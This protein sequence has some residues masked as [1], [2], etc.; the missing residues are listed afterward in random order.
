PLII[1]GAAGVT[2]QLIITRQPLRVTATQHRLERVHIVLAPGGAPA[3]ALL[4]VQCQQVIV[5][6]CRFHADDSKSSDHSISTSQQLTSTAIAWK[7]TDSANPTGGKLLMRDTVISGPL[8]AVETHTMPRLMRFDNCLKCGDGALARLSHPE[9]SAS[10]HV[11]LRQTTLRDS[12]GVVCWSPASSTGGLQPLLLIAEDSVLDIPPE[13]GALLVFAQ[14]EPAPDWE[15]MVRVTGEGSLLRTGTLLA[16]SHAG[17]SSKPAPLDPAQL[18]VE[19][20]LID[21]FEFAGADAREPAESV[22]ASTQTPRS[23]P[24]PPGIDAD[25]LADSTAARGV[26]KIVDQ[27]IR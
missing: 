27:L 8:Y 17:G 1:R 12:A 26:S 10:L 13:H 3:S 2:P 7:V 14:H 6:G 19:G 22:I 20:L 9:R 24:T 21:D 23:S 11:H 15:R 4:A 16:A 25:R 18:R 5:D